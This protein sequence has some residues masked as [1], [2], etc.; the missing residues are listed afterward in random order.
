MLFWQDEQS[1]SCSTKIV[2]RHTSHLIL[3]ISSLL[4]K[5]TKIFQT[6]WR[7]FAFLLVRNLVGGLMGVAVHV[8]VIF[9]LSFITNSSDSTIFSRYSPE[10]LHIIA[11]QSESL[12]FF[13]FL[14]NELLQPER[15]PLKWSREFLTPAII[16]WV[17]FCLVLFLSVFNWVVCWPCLY[18][19]LFYKEGDPNWA[20]KRKSEWLQFPGQKIK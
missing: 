13:E 10:F 18:L 1:E 20:K 8:Q 6:L 2:E 11:N 12:S 15:W 16:R 4:K 3:L 5:I 9:R 14:L 7:A 19:H 17:F